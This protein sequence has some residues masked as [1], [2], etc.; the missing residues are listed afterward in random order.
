MDVISDR[1]WIRICCKTVNIT[2]A[3]RKIDHNCLIHVI[4]FEKLGFCI[5]IFIFVSQNLLA[6]RFLHLGIENIMNMEERFTEMALA[7]QQLTHAVTRIEMNQQERVVPAHN[8]ERT[9]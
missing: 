9:T 6:E 5:C 2:I 4:C 3:L 7:I 8:H 1:N